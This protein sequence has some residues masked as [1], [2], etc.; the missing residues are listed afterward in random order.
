MARGDVFQK[1]L[2]RKLMESINAFPVYRKRDGYDDI[3]RNKEVFDA[4]AKH[5]S[6]N[7]VLA[8]YVEGRHHD[9]LRVLPAQKGIVRIAF[10]AYEKYRLERLAIYPMG[11]NYARAGSPRDEVMIN[12]G[13]PL[14]VKDYWADYEENS[15]RAINRLARDIEMALRPICLH[16]EHPDDDALADRLLTLHRS[17]YPARVF[18]IIE[19]DHPRFQREKA[20]VDRLNTMN[21]SEKHQLQATTAAYFG[22]LQQKGW[23]DEALVNA[24]TWGHAGRLLFLVLTFLPFLVGYVTSWPVL[25]LSHT[26]AH[27]TVRKKIFFGSVVIGT[28]FIGGII[29]YFLWLLPGL[30]LLSWKWIAAVLLSLPLGWFSIIWREH[31]KQFWAARRVLR[32]PAAREDLLRQRLAITGSE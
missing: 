20:I 6:E 24:S 26:V 16:L 1:P 18:P 2:Y 22:A 19:R 12:I 14:Y 28:G 7:Q 17:E 25:W 15:G 21:F 29:W 31:W 23:S 9:D 3:D 8:I 27:K 11:N 13:T 10:V 30:F 5:L 32:D 4:C